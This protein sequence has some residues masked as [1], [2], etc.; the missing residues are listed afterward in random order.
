MPYTS[1]R[2]NQI[3]IELL[4]YHG[5][6]KIVAS[7]GGTNLTFVASVQQDPFF[8]IY[9]SVDETEALKIM[10]TLEKSTSEN[11]KQTIK[12]I[13]GDKNASALKKFIKG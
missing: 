8:E 9:S 11:V 13:I 7:P 5:I 2:N 3:V 12:S 6:K 4:K 10:C 1:E